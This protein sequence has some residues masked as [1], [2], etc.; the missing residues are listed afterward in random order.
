MKAA[1][2]DCWLCL[3]KLTHLSLGGVLLQGIFTT[4]SGH[5][6]S[7]ASPVA[8]KKGMPVF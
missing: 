2:H 5:A 4:E 8:F 7:K 1:V 6:T 3:S